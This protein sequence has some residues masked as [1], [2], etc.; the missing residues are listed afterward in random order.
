MS[1]PLDCFVHGHAVR[2]DQQSH[3]KVNA[4]ACAVAAHDHSAASA[5]HVREREQF[6][7]LVN[8]GALGIAWV[9]AVAV[10]RHGDV[11]YPAC[12][13]LGRVDEREEIGEEESGVDLLWREWMS[14]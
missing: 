6:R 2:Q 10:S 11:V 8:V 7:G 4:L 3:D 1:H 13:E 5:A 12:V 14:G 9:G